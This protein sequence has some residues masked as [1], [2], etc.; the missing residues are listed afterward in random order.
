M[1]S[2]D[3]VKLRNVLP[4]TPIFEFGRAFIVAFGKPSMTVEIGAAARHACE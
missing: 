1:L 3:I 2:S 4:P